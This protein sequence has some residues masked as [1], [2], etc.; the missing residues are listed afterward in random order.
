MIRKFA[1]AVG[2]FCVCVAFGMWLWRSGGEQSALAQDSNANNAQLKSAPSSA[3]SS[4]AVYDLGPEHPTYLS[5]VW[6][7]GKAVF[8]DIK[9]F[10]L[11]LKD[12]YKRGYR[13]TQPIAFSHQVHVEKN[14]MECQYCHSGVA[15]SSFP[16]LPSTESCMGCH[17]AV[18]TDSPEIKKL[19]EYYDKGEPVPW[20]P[21]FS[22]PEHAHFNHQRHIKAG[23][24]C[25][26][27]H[28]QIQK[29][30]VVERVSSMKMGFCVSCH[31]ENGASIDCSVCHY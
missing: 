10:D 26:S 7:E 9:L 1:P 14:G 31:R 19:K 13:P 3:S 17:K 8:S 6:R 29:M 5:G 15:K 25:Q 22:I 2:A 18:K 20:K 23:V 28:G 11:F 16:T 21:V 24:G 30:A 27:C 4:P 12:Y